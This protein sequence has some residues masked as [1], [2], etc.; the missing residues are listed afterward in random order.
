MFRCTTEAA[1]GQPIDNFIP[2]RFRESHRHHVE[3]FGK[4]GVTSRSM[5]SP[6]ALNGLRTDG[7]EFPIEASISQVEFAGQRVFTV[8]LRDITERK[9]AAEVI[10]QLNTDLEQRV[11]LIARHSCSRPTMNWKRSAIPFP[12]T[13][14]PRCEASMVS[15]RL[16]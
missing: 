15:V 12:M 16:Y 11:L 5:R 14:A 9:R 2:E 4:T 6:S 1:L 10:R 8:I 7:E 13:C 3:D